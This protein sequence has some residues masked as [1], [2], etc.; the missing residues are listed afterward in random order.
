MNFKTILDLA[1]LFL[2]P[3]FVVLIPTLI[4]HRFGIYRR[5][6][7]D[8]LQHAPV[9]TIVGS[10]FA[11]LAFMLAFTFQIATNRYD[12]RKELLLEEVTNIRTTYLRAGLL[13]EPMRSD[14]KKL[15]IDYID[16]RADLARDTSTLSSAILRSQQI[17][18]NLW[19]YAEE[20]ADE[21]RSS[22][23]YALF[24]QSVND[25]FD[26][27]NQRITMTLEYRIPPLVIWILMIIAFFTMFTIGYQFGISG[28]GSFRI[29]VFLAI[30]FG[31]VMFLISSLDRPEK[32]LAR[33][34]QKPVISL[35]K[36]MHEM[37]LN[38]SQKIQAGKSID[39]IPNLG[40]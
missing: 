7:Q 11:L 28:K 9:G 27:F 38:D 24:T 2:I 20:L 10:A 26:N 30:I 19:D 8:E 22:E 21:D 15:L 18:N 12:A 37:Q 34:N 14:A 3:F 13:K 29:N 40:D 33:L 17:L 4:G 23:V 35:E 31:V 6:D 39:K 25:L 36:Q 5:K 32:G 1:G 16:I